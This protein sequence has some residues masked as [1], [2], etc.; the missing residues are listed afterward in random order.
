M[1][2]WTSNFFRL[3]LDLDLLC[4]ADLVLASEERIFSHRPPLALTVNFP[5]LCPDH[6]LDSSNSQCLI[7]ARC[8]FRKCAATGKVYI[9]LELAL[10]LNQMWAWNRRASKIIWHEVTPLTPRCCAAAPR[11]VCHVGL[12][13]GLVDGAREWLY[14]RTQLPDQNY[15]C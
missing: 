10:W 7:H 8:C 4:D 15:R 14:L 12:P 11:H 13:L 2:V 6:P 9:S 3:R 1:R 5:W